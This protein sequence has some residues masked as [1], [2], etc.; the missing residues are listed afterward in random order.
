MRKYQSNLAFV[1]FLFILLLAFI[2]MFILALILINPVTKKSEVERKAEFL[3]TLEW[4]KQSKDDVDIWVEDPLGKVVSF[5]NKTVDVMHLDKDDLGQI[6]DTIRFPDGSSQV[7]HLNREV[8]TL[9]GWVAGEYTINAHMYNKR[10]RSH[11][12]DAN[13]YGH[14]TKVKVEMLRINPYKILF[15]EKFTL[16]HRGEEV[17]IRRVTLN[18]DGEIVATNK[19]EKSF[20]TLSAY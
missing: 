13:S 16:T 8:V 14:P 20:V 17:T 1:D 5:R 3:I 19:R 10:D 9:R 15:E 11:P 6:N 18:K 7:I 4:D 12:S 2:S